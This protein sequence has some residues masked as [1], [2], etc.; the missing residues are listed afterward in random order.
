VGLAASHW[1][2]GRG[3]AGKLPVGSVVTAAR[4]PRRTITLEEDEEARM[5][6]AQRVRRGQFVK[7][8]GK[9]PQKAS[10]KLR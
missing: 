4:L 8:F 6:D 1:V 10:G 9:A 7:S 3:A 2:I 5:R